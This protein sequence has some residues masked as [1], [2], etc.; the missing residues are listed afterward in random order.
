MKKFLK[1]ILP[2]AFTVIAAGCS[3][4]NID[5]SRVISAPRDY[6]L[7][8]L[9]LGDTNGQAEGGQGQGIGYSRFSTVLERARKEFGRENVLYLDAGNA[10]YGSSIAETDR[11]ESVVKILNALGLDATVLGNND[12]NYGERAVKSLE[13]RANFKILATNVKTMD[14]EQNF[15]TPYIIKEI[16][17]TKVGIFG[18]TSPEAYDSE[19]ALLDNI[20]IEE[21][22]LAA[23]KTVKE[24]KSQGAEFII[25]L[26]HLGM[27]E[28]TNKEWQST[29][30]AENVQGIDLIIDGNSSEPLEDKVV[31]K[32][33]VIIQTGENLMNIGVLK[34]DFDAPRRDEERIFYKL[35]KKEDIVMVDDVAPQ[36]KEEKSSSPKFVTHTVVK[37]DTLYSLAKKYGT[38][39]GD[40][41]ALNP[42][43]EDGKTISIG[44]TY[45]MTSDA[46]IKETAP[47]I[48]EGVITHTVVKGDTL[49]SLAKKYGTTVDAVVALNPE[50]TDGQSIKIGQSYKFPTSS[51]VSETSYKAEEEEE[52]SGGFPDENPNVRVAVSSGIAKDPKIEELIVKIK[53]AQ[54]FMKTREIKDKTDFLK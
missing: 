52:V 46:K 23:S 10:F 47:Q 4:G 31:V 33:T 8:V 19:K 28:E 20:T 48:K 32:D 37:G 44:Q 39:V 35:I 34:I 43:I 36:M 13:M 53:T 41:V 25:L 54:S 49:Y 42:S 9:T 30:V 24:L 16:R 14:D 27:N 5:R 50:I 11:G 45:I 1:L 3:M 2:V 18:L 12:F 40:I 38:T 21:P 29:A 51:A 22:I 7:T 17:G 26:S 15:V 6:E